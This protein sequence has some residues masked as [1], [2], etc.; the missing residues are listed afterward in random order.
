M[1]GGGPSHAC[2]RCT[3]NAMCACKRVCFPS[4]ACGAMNECTRC[5]QGGRA[6]LGAAANASQLPALMGGSGTSY[7]MQADADARMEPRCLMRVRLSEP[8]ASEGERSSSDAGTATA[9]RCSAARRIALHALFQSNGLTWC[10][11]PVMSVR[12]PACSCN[13]TS[14]HSQSGLANSR[15]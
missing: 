4:G 15:A 10:P 11:S 7:G 14:P 12:S 1:I 9:V 6:S 13:G 8:G 5:A 3:R 2:M